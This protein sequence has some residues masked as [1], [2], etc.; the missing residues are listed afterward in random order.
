MARSKELK[1]K[2][3]E[4]SSHAESM[5]KTLMQDNL[6]FENPLVEFEEIEEQGEGHW[7][8]NKFYP[9]E[10]WEMKVIL[11][12]V[13]KSF[14][15]ESLVLDKNDNSLFQ[16]IA[17]KWF[18]IYL[19]QEDEEWTYF[20]NVTDRIVRENTSENYKVLHEPDTD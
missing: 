14:P 10:D 9:S 1:A 5:Y 6:V 19:N 15:D 7:V 20:P 8:D 18:F 17:G 16:K 4:Q 3:I 12:S 2:Y 13:V 11:T